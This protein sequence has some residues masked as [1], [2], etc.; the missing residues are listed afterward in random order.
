[1]LSK[2]LLSLWT[3]TWFVVGLAFIKERGWW[4]CDVLAH[5]IETKF[6]SK[7]NFIVILGAKC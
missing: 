6:V 5:L 1:M 2:L 4:D 3:R 7:Q